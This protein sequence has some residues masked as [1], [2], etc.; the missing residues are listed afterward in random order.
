MAIKSYPTMKIGAALAG[1]LALRLAPGQAF[2]G[3]PRTFSRQHEHAPQQCQTPFRIGAKEIS[4]RGSLRRQND[5]KMVRFIY[6][7]TLIN[8]VLFLLLKVLSIPLHV[9]DEQYST[10][11]TTAGRLPHRC[12]RY[13]TFSRTYSEKEHFRSL[14]I[15]KNIVWHYGS[16]HNVPGTS[17]IAL[18]SLK[19]SNVRSQL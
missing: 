18:A 12:I 6:T 19:F 8:V 11:P 14:G 9:R 3:V 7:T 4:G 2:G 17:I 1:G 13:S 10:L 16:E 15:V 5:F